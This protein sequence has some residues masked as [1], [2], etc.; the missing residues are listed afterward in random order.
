M[1]PAEIPQGRR[2]VLSILTKAQ[3]TVNKPPPP[4]YSLTAFASAVTPTKSMF[5]SNGTFSARSPEVM[6]ALFR[7]RAQRKEDAASRIQRNYRAYLRRRVA[8]EE[9][10]KAKAAGE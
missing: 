2:T 5:Y 10:A 9:E 3:R 6:K 7:T 4:K 8:A 1:P